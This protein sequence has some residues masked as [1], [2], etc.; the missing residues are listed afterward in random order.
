MPE[1]E[2]LGVRAVVRDI[3][4][5]LSDLGRMNKGVQ[6]SAQQMQRWGRGMQTAGMQMTKFVTLP[7][8]ALGAGSLKMASDFETA[9][10]EVT[11]LFDL[12]E[13]QV[14]SL[15]SE[16][17]EL[18][19]SMGVDPV[20]AARAMYQAISAGVPAANVIGFLRENVKLAVG[21]VSDLETV[22]DLTTT[23]MNA[24]GKTTEDITDIQDSLFLAVRQG[25]TTIAE[26]G[27]AYFQVAPVAAA[28]GFT[29]DET[30]ATLATLALNG[31]PTSEALTQIR[32]AMLALGAPT[33]RQ[34]K[35]QCYFYL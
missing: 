30:N 33:I 31:V 11:T 34:K 3:G 28:F 24:W 6:T 17:L 22:V 14:K 25:K 32:A 26:L 29:V 23:V 18:A 2:D 15:R 10:T 5:F 9:F 1:F 7:I 27:Q 19:R 4:K 13:S 20:E 8:V 21:G 12:S 35:R 16:V